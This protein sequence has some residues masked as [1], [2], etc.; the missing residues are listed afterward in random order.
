[1]AFEFDRQ[2]ARRDVDPRRV[3][4]DKALSILGALNKN[5]ATRQKQHYDEMLSRLR[6]VVTPNLQRLPF[7]GAKRVRGDRNLDFAGNQDDEDRAWNRSSGSV[8]MASGGWR[9]RS[10]NPNRRR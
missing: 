9:E 1:M 3:A 8:R 5:W 2:Q 4:F 10:N 6:L 7:A